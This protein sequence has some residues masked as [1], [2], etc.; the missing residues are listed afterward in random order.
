MSKSRIATVLAGAVFAV[1]ASASALGPQTAAAA[2][3]VEVAQLELTLAADRLDA[4]V[5]AGLVPCN[6]PIGDLSSSRIAAPEPCRLVDE[7]AT[8]EPPMVP[9]VPAATT[10]AYGAWCKSGRDNDEFTWVTIRNEPQGLTIGNCREG[11]SMN[12][13][14]QAEKPFDGGYIAGNFSSCGWIE[15]GHLETNGGAGDDSCSSPS[16]SRSEFLRYRNCGD[17]TDGTPVRNT[18]T[19]QVHA[20]VKPWRNPA[21]P[22]NHIYDV[23]PNSMDPSGNNTPRLKWRYLARYSDW[24][25]VR[26]SGRASGQGNWGFVHKGCLQDPLPGPHV[27]P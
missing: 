19:C 12:V 9:T 5:H 10:R 27:G 16:R 18:A 8:N 13:A 1:S 4:A 11:W 25:L 7:V 20:N 6:G 14:R 2:D 3:L 23:Q 21:E 24:V 26:D 17:C 15:A 22:T